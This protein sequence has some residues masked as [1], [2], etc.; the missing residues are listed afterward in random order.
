L[1]LFGTASH[2]AERMSSLLPAPFGCGTRN[3]E[4]KRKYVF[5]HL[6][7]I[8]YRTIACVTTEEAIRQERELRANRAVYMFQT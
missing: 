5:D 6:G 7:E 2:V 4:A 3:N 1:V 8:E